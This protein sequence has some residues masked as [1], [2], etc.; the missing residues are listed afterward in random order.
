MYWT[1]KAMS[2]KI[3]VQSDFLVLNKLFWI[4]GYTVACW[5]QGLMLA[6]QVLYCWAMSTTPFAL[7]IL[8]IESCALPTVAW[9]MILLLYVSFYI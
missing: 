2:A 7:V 9:N 4:F 8:E 6:K 5:I 1:G 3:W